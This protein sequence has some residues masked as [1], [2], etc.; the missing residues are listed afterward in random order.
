MATKTPTNSHRP[1]LGR[2]KAIALVVGVAAWVLFLASL[3]IFG[4][5]QFFESYLFAYL[6]WLGLSLG[7]LSALML[8]HLVSGGWGFM[9]Q[10]TIEAATRVLPVFALLF[11]P[12]LL[13][14]HTLYPWSNEAF[15]A[16]HGVV[17]NK[18]L[19]LNLPFFL[20]RAAVCFTIFLGLAHFLNRWSARLDES[21]DPRLI[22][23][24]QRL[25]AIGLVVYV[26]AMTFAA[27]DWA[28][29]LEP[30]WFSS[31]YGGLFVINQGLATLVFATF[32]VIHLSKYAPYLGGRGCASGGRCA[33][34][35]GC[36][37][38]PGC[39]G[40]KYQMYFHH[41]GNL[42]LGFV[43]LWAYFSFSQY[44]I[45]WSGNLT[46]EVPWYLR[47]AEGVYNI[48]AVALIVFHFAVP[49]FL[50]LIRRAK[51][52]RLP[53]AALCIG[54][55]LMHFVDLFWVIIPAFEPGALL[56]HFAVDI[57]AWLAFGGLWVAAFA[58]QLGRRPLL[59]QRDERMEM[60]YQHHDPSG[61]DITILAPAEG[62]DSH[63]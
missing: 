44:L 48:L 22:V 25:S 31:I 58:W 61:T 20:I 18:V 50:L 14:L 7:S 1:N 11:L 59:P 37:G 55:F 60:M 19:Y 10:R 62:A 5:K 13:G 2:V 36:L 46:E 45:I 53:L 17:A 35:E 28:M 29:S 26:L 40:V 56:R 47:R 6:F 57:I 39:A 49:F 3:A 38:A 33:E 34:A 54:V 23:R 21:G 16:E 4:R 52:Q 12:L 15:V 41:L 8:H 51:Q 9:I 27:V 63:A 30:E 42:I 32:V 24:M 43:V